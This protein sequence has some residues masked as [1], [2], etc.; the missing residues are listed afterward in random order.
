MFQ[1]VAFKV[2]GD[3]KLHCVSC[4]QRVVRTLK[5]L[6]GVH[7]VLADAS[8]QRIEVLYDPGELEESAIASRLDLL[9]YATEPATPPASR[10][11]E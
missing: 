4:E 11:T 9:G 7:Q 2:I 1:S 6:T 10:M 5:T 8:A 3:Q